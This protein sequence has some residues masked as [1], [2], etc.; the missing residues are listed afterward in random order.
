[1]VGEASA[2][3][4]ELGEVLIDKGAWR[5]EDYMMTAAGMNGGWEE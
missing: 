5:G 3:L 2:R 1:M 4:R